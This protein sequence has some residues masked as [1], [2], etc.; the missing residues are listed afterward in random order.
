MRSSQKPLG[1]GKTHR[2]S[3]SREI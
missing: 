2:Y 3:R 1:P